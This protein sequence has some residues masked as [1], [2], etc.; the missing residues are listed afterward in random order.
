[1]TK[2]PKLRLVLIFLVPLLFVYITSLFWVLALNHTESLPYKLFLIRK[3]ALPEKGQYAVFKAPSNGRY[4]QP[5]IK[6]VGGTEG[7]I[8]AR[9]GRGYYVSGKYIGDAKEFSKAGEP[10]KLGPVGVIPEGSYFVYTNNKDSYDSRYEEIGWVKSSDIL[11]V[12]Y[13][14]Y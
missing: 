13:P 10:T 14:I 1:M 8:V 6:R 7:D 12:A 5:F 11:G 3:D 9:D 4:N 2:V